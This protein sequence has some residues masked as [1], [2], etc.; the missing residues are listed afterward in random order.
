MTGGKVSIV[1]LAALAVATLLLGSLAG[2]QFE[3]SYSSASLSEATMCKSIDAQNRPVDKTDVFFPNTPE[4]FCSFKYSYA[5]EDTELKAQF[6]YV[7]GEAQGVANYTMAETSIRTEKNSGYGYFS[8][9]SP[10]NGWPR[11]DYVVKLFVDGTEK[12]TVPFKVQDSTAVQPG[13]VPLANIFQEP[14][15]GYTIR[16]PADWTYETHETSRNVKVIFNSQKGVDTAGTLAIQN[17]APPQSSGADAGT[18]AIM[19]SYIDAIKA[20]DANARISTWETFTFPDT[21]GQQLTGKLCGIEY[22]YEGQKYRQ[23]LAVF[24]RN[25]GGDAFHVLSYDALADIFDTNLPTVQAMSSSFTL[26]KKQ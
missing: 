23:L 24:P 15:F 9:T 21:E 1:A 14:G 25:V 7:Q 2:C 10:T 18:N 4:I 20:E 19:N 6:I 5:P 13:A 22:T 12:L 17:I 3:A 26:T 8:C 16:Y 11:G